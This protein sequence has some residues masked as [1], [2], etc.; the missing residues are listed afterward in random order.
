MDKTIKTRT[1]VKNIKIFDAKAA[2]AQG[3]NE[4]SIKTK[5]AN[6]AGDGSDQ[7]HRHGSDYAQS[8]VEQ[9]AQ[10]SITAAGRESAKGARR[11][12]DATRKQAR[13][14]ASKRAAQKVEA[15]S[16][17]TSRRSV[18]GA[19]NRGNQKTAK[20]TAKS[21]K[22]AGAATGKGVKTSQQTTRA[23]KLSSKA[24]QV[25]E[26]NAAQAARAATRAM[27]AAAKAAIKAFIAF[28][29]M[30]IAAI[31]SLAA[32]IAAGGWVA[33]AVI[34]IVCLVGFIATSAYGIFFTGGDVGD[35]NPTLRE[36]VASIDKDYQA[37]INKIEA[38]S[39][40]D[41]VMISGSRASWSD[42]LAVYAV[43]TTTNVSDPL[44][45]ITLDASR[46][47]T[48]KGI[49]WDMNTLSYQ[50]A[51]RTYTEVAAANQTGNVA[52][53]A[54]QV[55]T[56]KTLYITQGAKTAKQ[57]ASAYSFDASQQ[58]LLADLQSAR[59]VS[60]WQ[61]VLYGSQSGSED[62]V[63]AAASQVDETGGQP[64]WSWYGF[65]SRV[66]WCACFVSWCANQCGYIKAGT[67]LKFS[68]CQTGVNWF[69]DAGQ[70]QNAHSGYVPKP[71]DII[72]FDWQRDGHSDHVGIVEYVKDGYLHTIEGNSSDAVHRRSYSLSSSVLMGYGSTNR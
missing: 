60:A 25:A 53:D 1:V 33:V 38:D 35:G 51:D 57:I 27:T 7:P 20:I 59:Y 62:I 22:G 18:Q 40:H 28:V 43:K 2:M 46:Q 6:E 23:A 3:V 5:G 19:I 54:T 37:K 31:K 32:A 16:A 67:M 13:Q 41:D 10:R 11:A 9:S 72:F 48:L 63:E 68:Y 70:W 4:V 39:P 66:E 12:V 65:S 42:V 64:Y 58:A 29:K 69:K 55:Q 36:V 71:G 24:A 49:F 44:D 45:V 61:T 8:K 17:S 52:S 15:Q 26:R 34:L 47:K 50:V 21:I 56:R 30:A 14:V